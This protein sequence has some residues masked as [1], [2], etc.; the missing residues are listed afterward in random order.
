[1]RQAGLRRAN[2]RARVAIQGANLEALTGDGAFLIPLA[3]CSL[4]ADGQKIIVRDQRTSLAIWSD[5]DRFLRALEQAER[6]ILS[7]RVHSLRATARRRRLLKWCGAAVFATGAICAAAVPLTRWA[8]GGGIPSLA[9]RIGESALERL[10]FPAGIAPD[11]DGA[12]ATIAE[13][14]R[15]ATA[16]ST[17]SFHLLLAGYSEVHSFDIP[18]STIVVTAGLLCAAKDPESVTAVVARELAHLEN[19]D[20][21]K[22]VAGAVDWHTPIDLV[23]GDMSTLRARMLDFADPGR[24]PGFP[25]EQETAAEQRASV[26]LAAIAAPRDAARVKDEAAGTPRGLD[27]SKVRAEAC[28]LAG[29]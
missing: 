27:W 19:H 9:D 29:R 3:R 15:P 21:S 10:A 11:T 20:V 6:G 13:Q 22:R 24:Y 23:R 1:V 4:D 8:I 12:L 17:R 26:I 18:A 28:E 14:L 7:R 16:A 25:P 5:D 2:V